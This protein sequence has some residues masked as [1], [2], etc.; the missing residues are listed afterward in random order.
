MKRQSMKTVAVWLG[1]LCVAV[2]PFSLIAHIVGLHALDL[3]WQ[4]TVG[5]AGIGALLVAFAS[6]LFEG[7]TIEFSKSGIKI[8]D[9]K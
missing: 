7:K 5:C 6:G 1:V 9:A 4:Y 8:V 2:L 3:P